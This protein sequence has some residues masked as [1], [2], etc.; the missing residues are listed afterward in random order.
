MRA[1]FS[2]T[3]CTAERLWFHRNG[4]EKP[5][6]LRDAHMPVMLVGFDHSHDG[7]IE[8]LKVRTEDGMLRLCFPEELYTGPSRMSRNAFADERGE[9]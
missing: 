2:P 6:Y 8:R 4:H 3:H 9:P 5:T 7:G 1:S